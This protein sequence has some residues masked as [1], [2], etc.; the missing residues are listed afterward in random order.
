MTRQLEN[1]DDIRILVNKFY[2]KIRQDDLVSEIFINR[3]GNRW[4]EHLEKMCAFWQTVLL[5]EY[6]YQGSPFLPHANLPVDKRHF[7]RWLNLFRETVDELFV[8]AKA[9]E[10]K[11]RAEKMAEMFL[12]KIEYHRSNSSTSLK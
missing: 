1:I 7:E 3:I 12:L 10:A 5:H 6:A 4:P 9:T 2:E 8:G 11:W